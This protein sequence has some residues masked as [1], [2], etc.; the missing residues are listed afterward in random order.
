VI[1]YVDNLDDPRV[2]AYRHVGDHRWLTA[3]GL[4]VAEGRLLLERLA[5]AASY[6]IDSV[7]VSP[8]A[9]DALRPLLSALQPPVYVLDRDL[10]NSI[11]GFNF[12]RGCLA[13]ARR[14]AALPLDR[15]SRARLLL[16]L[17]AI[18]NP[19]NVG[20]LFRTAA[21]LGADAVLL[22]EAS[23]DPFYRKALRTSMGTVL[24]VPF[25]RVA[26]WSEFIPVLRAAAVAVVALTTDPDATAIDEISAHLDMRGRL[27]I[28][29]GNEGTGLSASVRAAADARVRIPMSPGVD[30]LNVVVAAGIALS[31]IR[32]SMTHA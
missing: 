5:A 29:A 1:L 32:R 20:G 16:G 2:D 8:A 23:G 27:L 24:T 28:L 15:L 7:L 17:E 25:G 30:S 14:P 4:L 19:D 9:L 31:W 13:L 12:H 18:G 11:T 3:H 10:I 22:D 6:E 26:S 21:A